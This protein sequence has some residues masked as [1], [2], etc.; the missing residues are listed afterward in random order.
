MKGKREGPCE[1]K[2]DF[3]VV[4]RALLRLRTQIISSIFSSDCGIFFPP[5]IFS[6]LTIGTGEAHNWNYS[7]LEEFRG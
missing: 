5:E 2:R 3:Q 1:M 7:R 4:M 6:D